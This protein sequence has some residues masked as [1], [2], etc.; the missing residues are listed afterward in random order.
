VADRRKYNGH[1][2]QETHVR[3]Y[4]A[5]DFELLYRID[6]ACFDPDIAYSRSELSFYIRRHGAITK[7]AETGS[8][9]EG[10]AVGKSDAGG[11]S[12]VITLDIAAGKRRHGL[13]TMLMESLHEEFRARK[14]RITVL[15]VSVLNAGAIR[16]YE[17]LG[18]QRG[19]VLPGYYN[20]RVDGLR[21]FR[22]FPHASALGFS[23]PPDR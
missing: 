20:G 7:V 17:T 10:F 16:F 13:G 3:N 2:N 9:I 15:E 19:E 14:A 8:Q 12:H 5:G 23:S 4:R 21:M 6:Q 22:F 11:I 1:V 18:Y